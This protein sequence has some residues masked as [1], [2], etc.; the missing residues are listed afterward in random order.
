MSPISTARS[1]SLRQSGTPL[2]TLR[3]AARATIGLNVRSSRNSKLN[4]WREVVK[5][6]RLPRNPVDKTESARRGVLP[7]W[8]ICISG[9]SVVFGLLIRGN[10]PQ[11]LIR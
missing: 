2:P 8:F 1:R 3:D 7:Q 9:D 4:H 6:E 5:I 11:D 10:M